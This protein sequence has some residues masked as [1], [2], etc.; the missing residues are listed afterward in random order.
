M[1]TIEILHVI[2]EER[3]RAARHSELVRAARSARVHRRTLADRIGRLIGRV[4]AD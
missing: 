2:E 3:R 4:D 1:S